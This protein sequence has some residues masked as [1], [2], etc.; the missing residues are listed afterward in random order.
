[1][2]KYVTLLP[3][4]CLSISDVSL[5]DPVKNYLGGSTE[6][7]MNNNIVLYNSF[8]LY[9]F[10]EQAFTADAICALRL[11]VRIRLREAGYLKLIAN[12]GFLWTP[13][14]ASTFGELYESISGNAYHGMAVEYSARIPKFGPVSLTVSMPVFSRDEKVSKPAA[15]IFYL[16][17]GHDF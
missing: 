15:P 14:I 9:G 16:S 7:R 3:S 6:I 4:G 12:S 13:D 2:S 5:P 17:L 10:E 1:V 8:P 11:G